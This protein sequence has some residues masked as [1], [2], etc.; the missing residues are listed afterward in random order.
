MPGR[1]LPAARRAARQYRELMSVLVAAGLGLALPAP[2]RALV[3]AGGVNLVLAALVFTAAL[4]VPPL[5]QRL[6]RHVAALVAM[7]VVSGVAVAASAWMAAHLVD[8]GPLRLGV[9]AAGVAPVEIATLGVAPLAAGDALSSGVLLIAST[10]LTAAFAGPA[11]ALL[12]GGA[13]VRTGD[14]AL[15]LLVVVVAPFVVGLMLRTRLSNA[16]HSRAAEAATA[17]V[18]VLVWLTASE[19]HLSAAY[20]G[21][22]AAYV[23]L[24]GTGAVIG[25]V[26]GR[27]ADGRSSVSLVFA[28]SMRDFAVAAGIATAAFGPAAAAPLG[29]YGILVM[30][31]GTGLAAT[32][33]RRQR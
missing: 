24:I 32:L 2:G 29:V 19:A 20:G 7:A 22:V 3:R 33:R 14:L 9:I 30:V 23:V 27:F 28:G 26:L 21:V 6:G 8:A 5:A 16:M 10:V 15:T 25:A 4:G 13:T 17:A 12:G 1:I 11:L 31:W 18:V